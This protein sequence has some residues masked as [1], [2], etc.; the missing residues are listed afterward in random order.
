M[1][2]DLL[3]WIK[4][5]IDIRGVSQRELARK[6]GRSNTFFHLVL[7][8]KRAITLTFCQAIADGLNVPIWKIFMLAGITEAPPEDVVRNE[9]VKILVKGYEELSTEDKADLMKYLDW[10]TVKNKR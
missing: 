5:E 8:E 6:T 1:E 3:E 7:A 2:K 9:D 10:L 4:K